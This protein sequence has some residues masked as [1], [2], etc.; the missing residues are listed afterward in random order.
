MKPHEGGRET[1]ERTWVGSE[2]LSRIE[3]LSAYPHGTAVGV[4][5]LQCRKSGDDRSATFHAG[6]VVADE[7]GAALKV[8]DA[9][10]AEKTSRAARRQHVARAGGEIAEGGRRVFANEDRAGGG[11]FLGDVG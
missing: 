6:A 8:G 10:A 4:E 2:R 11:D 3:L 1:K 5:S 9:Q 7:A